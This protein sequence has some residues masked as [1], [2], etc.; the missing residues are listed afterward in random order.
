MKDH[1]SSLINKVRA[2]K[3]V[4]HL[5]HWQLVFSKL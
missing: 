2:F 5:N 1:Y 4:L 3:A